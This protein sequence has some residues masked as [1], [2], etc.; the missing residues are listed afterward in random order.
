MQTL[1]DTLRQQLAESDDE[2]SRNCV[3]ADLA[4]YLARS[5][6]YAEAGLA[7]AELSNSGRWASPTLTA[8]TM[9]AEA[10]VMLRSEL[11][12]DALDRLRRAHALATA[13][14]LAGLVVESAAWLFHYNFNRDDYSEMSRWLRECEQ[15]ANDAT[16]HAVARLS[17]TFA[18]ICGYCGDHLAA[19][20]WYKQVR[21]L[22][23]TLRDE[24][25]LASSMYNRPAILIAA[26]RLE[27][28]IKGS[29]TANLDQLTLEIESA[30]NYAVATS[31]GSARQLQDLWKGRAQM[32]QG[33][34]EL[35]LQGIELAIATLPEAKHPT[36]SVSLEM[37][38]HVCIVRLDSATNAADQLRDLEFESL[39]TDDRLV[40]LAQ[41]EQLGIVV[42][43]DER[44]KRLR[45]ASMGEYQSQVA[46]LMRLSSRFA[47]FRRAT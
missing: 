10:M 22:A 32:L 4:S 6:K 9:L 16:P 31:N 38:R 36:L 19:D 33:R 41:L 1:A 15:L 25:F 42:P 21:R 3:R 28:A 34:F 24:A 5:G 44:L 2:H 7:L 14:K 23:T 37:D 40:A 18:A 17:L 43:N 46:E 29:T 12:L 13:G 45:D 26:A 30:Q 35:A 47:R 11:S 27:Q 20:A 39:G 8:K